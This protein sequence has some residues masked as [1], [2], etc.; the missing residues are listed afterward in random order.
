M[1]PP[2]FCIDRGSQLM[3]THSL[4]TSTDHWCRLRW[5]CGILLWSALLSFHPRSIL[6]AD[7][8]RI[9]DWNVLST[10][11]LSVLPQ[12]RRH[13]FENHLCKGVLLESRSRFR[14]SRDFHFLIFYD[15]QELIYHTVAAILLLIASVYLLVKI[16]DYKNTE[17][18]DKYIIVAVSVQRGPST[19]KR[20]LTNQY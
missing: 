12:H 16:N 20:N 7:G 6:F 13:H 9:L 2:S 14:L 3:N 10:G 15:F 18:Y 11:V 8:H 1:H 17:L 5:N 19:I 4:S